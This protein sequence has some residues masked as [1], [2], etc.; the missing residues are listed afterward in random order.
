MAKKD[1]EILS[2]LYKDI[3]TEEEEI[4]LNDFMD[5]YNLL[6]DK[7]H[8]D[9]LEDT[10][11]HELKRYRL[12]V[13]EV[14]NNI[15]SDSKDYTPAIKIINERMNKNYKSMDEKFARIRRKEPPKSNGFAT[16]VLILGSTFLAGVALGT[17]LWFIR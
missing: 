3:L 5:Y 13:N 8:E 7:E 17:L 15:N 16:I 9:L 12:V 6:L 2:L 10:E 4:K 11:K 1:K 14:L